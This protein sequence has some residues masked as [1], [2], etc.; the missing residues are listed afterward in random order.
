[1]DPTA[2]QIAA[3]SDFLSKIVSSGVGKS[4]LAAISGVL[5]Y[6]FYEN[7]HTAI[8]MILSN[9]PILIFLGVGAT[10]TAIGSVFR[11]LLLRADIASQRVELVKDERITELKKELLESKAFQ[12]GILRDIEMIKEAIHKLVDRE[13]E[14]Y[15]TSSKIGNTDL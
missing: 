4:A 12:E 9:P 5:I 7:R 15:A 13:R 8:Q 10:L 2:E 3:T 14:Q 11:F 1:M 6:S